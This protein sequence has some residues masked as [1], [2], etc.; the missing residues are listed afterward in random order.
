MPRYDDVV[1]NKLDQ[2]AECRRKE[3][4]DD[5]G[6]NTVDEFDESIERILD[7]K[8]I[9]QDAPRPFTKIDHF[10]GSDQVLQSDE[11]SRNGEG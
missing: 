1:A 11:K 8:T 2:M 7:Y 6:Y 9:V 10:T 5:F 3:E 4:L